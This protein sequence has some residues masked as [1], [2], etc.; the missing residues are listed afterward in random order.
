MPQE[1]DKVMEIAIFIR[2]RYK[3]GC[4]VR[5]LMAWIDK[6]GHDEYDFD[7]DINY[8]LVDGDGDDDDDVLES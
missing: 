8:I 3:V 5:Y 7:K 4:Q 6:L 2:F 1:N